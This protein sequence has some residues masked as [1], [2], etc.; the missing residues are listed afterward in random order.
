MAY[1]DENLSHEQLRRKWREH[2][3]REGWF[4]ATGSNFEESERRALELFGPPPYRFLTR[5]DE[6]PERFLTRRTHVLLSEDY[7]EKYPVPGY[8]QLGS[9]PQF[10]DTRTGTQWWRASGDL[11]DSMTESGM[12]PR[13]G[14]SPI[15][16]DPEAERLDS[17]TQVM[18]ARL[19]IRAKK[20]G[21]YFPRVGTTLYLTHQ[22]SR[23]RCSARLDSLF[24]QDGRS[25]G[26]AIL[27]HFLSNVL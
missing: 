10:V 9:K 12:L 11:V 6:V 13:S 22:K 25:T 20:E 15:Q 3:E 26:F 7:L 27:K 1:R 18:W 23:V 2:V 5:A 17:G 24:V 14:L 21:R 4:K 8:R 19:P 16:L